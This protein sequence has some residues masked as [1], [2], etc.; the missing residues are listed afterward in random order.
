MCESCVALW[1]VKLIWINAVF[2]SCAPSCKAT[3]RDGIRR[4]VITMT[5][6]SDNKAHGLANNIWAQLGL[7]T[8]VV[9][10]AIGLAWRYVW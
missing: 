4:E 9:V 5:M 2:G 8:V 6:Q 3:V 10:I 7:L 1:P